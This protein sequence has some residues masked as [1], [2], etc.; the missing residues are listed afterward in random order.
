MLQ[1][2]DAVIFDLDGTLVD[3]MWM[4]ESIDVEFLAIFGL[5]LPKDLQKAIEG[6]SF[7]ETA[8]Y[9][10]ERFQIPWEVAEIKEKW[11]AMAMDKYT[12]QV[13]LKEGVLDFLHYLKQHNIPCGIATSNSKE[14]V[15]AVLKAHHLESYFNSVTTGCEVNVGK[16]APDIY[17]KV[18]RDLNVH[19]NRCLVFEDVPAGIKAGK[20]AG[21]KVCA[22]A[23]PYSHTVLEEKI[24]LADYIIESFGEL[25]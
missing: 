13:P 12:S 25:I 3:S 5:E 20:A 24:A 2:I 23:D 6:M 19:P 7:S 21:M 10:K 15:S 11:N 16:P 22:I 18:A 14:L 8:H 9:F 17:L 1:D 4:W